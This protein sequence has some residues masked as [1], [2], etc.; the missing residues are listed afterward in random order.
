MLGSDRKLI[1]WE[2][3]QHRLEDFDID[4]NSDYLHYLNENSIKSDNN[5][6]KD[7]MNSLLK[8]TKNQRLSFSEKSL[9]YKEIKIKKQKPYDLASK[10]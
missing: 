6:L 7:P 1:N 8:R 10:Y 2:N 3:V 4:W 5:L 9:I